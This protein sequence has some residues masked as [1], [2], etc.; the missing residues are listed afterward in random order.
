MVWSSELTSSSDDGE[1]VREASSA[2]IS[3]SLPPA[4]LRVVWGTGDTIFDPSGP[5]WLDRTYFHALA[6]C[7]GPKAQ[8]CSFR[9]S[10]RRYRRGGAGTVVR[11]VATS[12]PARCPT[13]G[14]GSG[15]RRLGDLLCTGDVERVV[16]QRLH[17]FDEA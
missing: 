13:P 12:S 15:R 3:W 9:R 2:E 16:D 11:G 5:D 14:L 17:A 8:S 6:A 10:C 1:S 7:E 4:Q